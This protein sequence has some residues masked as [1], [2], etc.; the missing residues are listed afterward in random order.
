MSDNPSPQPRGFVE[1]RDRS[2]YDAARTYATDD[3]V[4][5]VYPKRS[6]EHHFRAQQLVD[7]RRNHI[8]PSIQGFNV[9]MS[10]Y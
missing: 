8:V 6:A 2:D 5:E 4:Y 1:T 3:S 7:D 9:I 10:R